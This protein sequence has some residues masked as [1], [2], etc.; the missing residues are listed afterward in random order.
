MPIDIA[1]VS[2]IT[3]HDVA[4]EVRLVGGPHFRMGRLE[5]Q[6]DG[7]WGSVC[8][9][10]YFDNNAATVV[11]R[12][13]GYSLAGRPVK[14]WYEK[15]QSKCTHIP[16]RHTP[17]FLLYIRISFPISCS[18]GGW[19]RHTSWSKLQWQRFPSHPTARGWSLLCQCYLHKQA[20]ISS[21]V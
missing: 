16:V 12:Q 10:K 21:C 4:D 7:S 18:M 6:T 20:R 19:G 13:L 14:W 17:T 3:G 1:I 8:G 2:L 9:D 5:V 11:C 15:Y